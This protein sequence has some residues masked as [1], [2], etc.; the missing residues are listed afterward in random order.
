MHAV[1]RRT[2]PVN[3]RLTPRL[4]RAARAL[5]GLEQ[6]DLASLSGV[7]RSTIAAFEIK[8]ENARLMTTNNRALINA[9]ERAG[10]WFIPESET[11]GLGIRLRRPASRGLG[12]NTDQTSSED[13]R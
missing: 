12:M 9:F 1:F 7:S 6:N 5:S 3:V 2:L 8:G 13:D 11:E 4:C 10:L